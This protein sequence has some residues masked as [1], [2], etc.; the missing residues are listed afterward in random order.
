MNSLYC[1]APFGG[2]RYSMFAVDLLW[3]MLVPQE[4]G[5]ETVTT[6]RTS[7]VWKGYM[8]RSAAWCPKGSFGTLLSPPQCHAAFSTVLYT[9]ASVDQS[10]VC[11]LR[12]L[13][14]RD[15]DCPLPF[16][17]ISSLFRFITGCVGSFN[18]IKLAVNAMK[19]IFG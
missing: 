11:C 7:I 2:I 8:R 12:A 6:S 18:N 3:T 10:P 4:P 19:I 17:I 14:L 13:L 16:H 1:R 9:L 15:E 5:N